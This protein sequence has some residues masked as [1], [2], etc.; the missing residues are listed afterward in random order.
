MAL[1]REHHDFKPAISQTKGKLPAT[2]AF[3]F[4][5]IE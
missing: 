1:Q 2:H 5:L 4:T 3:L